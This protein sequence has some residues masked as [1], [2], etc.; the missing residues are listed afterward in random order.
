MRYAL[1]WALFALCAALAAYLFIYKSTSMS[2][3]ERVPAAASSTV[4]SGHR[5]PPAGTKEYRSTKYYASLFYPENLAVKTYD[6]G[7]GAATVTFQDIETS[8]GFQIFITPYSGT[9]VTPERFRQ[10]A[11]SGVIESPMD[12]TVGGIAARSFY[13]RDA[14]LGDT[15]E[16]WILYK[17]YLYEITAHKS[18]AAWLSSIL[19]SWQF[20][21]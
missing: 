17:G 20:A 11:P 6:E 14:F 12:V 21:P 16:V 3:F 2:A 19:A 7:G 4:S 5:I 9:Q 1:G 18:Q 13:G 8:Q 10:D 15:A